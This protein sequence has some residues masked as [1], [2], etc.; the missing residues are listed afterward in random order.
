MTHRATHLWASPATRALTFGVVVAV[1]ALAIGALS[2][3]LASDPPAPSVANV[4][5]LRPNQAE[6]LVVQS[7]DVTVELIR[8]PDGSWSGGEGV[9][10][11]AETLMRTFEDRLLPLPAYRVLHTDSSAPQF[12]LEQPE[13]TMRVTGKDGAT[14]TMAIGASTFT[15]GVF[16][17]RVGEDGKV[18]LIPR[19]M[20]DDL[21]S[22]L[23]GQRIDAENELARKVRNLEREAG[24]NAGKQ[25]VSWWLQ[26][27]LDAGVQLPEGLG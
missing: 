16:A 18:Y 6:R 27:T 10:P 4:L 15:K 5:S 13:L 14:R 2:R 12:G 9:P 26:Q 20:A 24:E 11:E 25:R 8:A 7:A 19:R 1:G 3:E 23:A 21:R 17:R 22:L